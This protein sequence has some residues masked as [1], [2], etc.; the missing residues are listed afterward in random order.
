M[1]EPTYFGRDELTICA[2]CVEATYYQGANPAALYTLQLVYPRFMLPQVNTYCSA[3]KNTSSSRAIPVKHYVKQAQQ[4]P[5]LPRVVLANQAGMVGGAEV[6]DE[7][8]ADFHRNIKELARQASVMVEL[9]EGR[10]HK[11]H[12]NRYLE[13]FM[14]VTQLVTMTLDD[15]GNLLAQR[16]HF[17]AQPEFQMLAHHILWAIRSAKP[18]RIEPLH[19]NWVPTQKENVGDVLDDYFNSHGLHYGITYNNVH[20]PYVDLELDGVNIENHIVISAARCAA[21][22]YFHSEDDGRS[23]VMDIHKARKI[24]YEKLLHSN[25]DEPKH[26][27]PFEHVAFAFNQPGS[28][29]KGYLQLRTCLQGERSTF[30]W[31]G[32]GVI[33][34][35]TFV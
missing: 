9:Y 33:D 19:T 8:R 18:R 2:Q 26:M 12:L 32:H 4:K 23:T 15:W 24:V 31:L 13:P 28:K 29:F 7:V 21:V 5:V 10:I 35:R 22:S 34:P 14:N 17:R 25:T 20:L 30:D 27:S 16:Y 6:D 11:Q 1:N 3:A